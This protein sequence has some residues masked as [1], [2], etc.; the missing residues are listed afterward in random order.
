MKKA[1]KLTVCAI[2]LPALG[3]A[4]VRLP[5]LN[6][7][8][9]T[10][11]VD[12]VRDIQPIFQ[13]SCYPCH[14][15]KRAM[16]QLRFDE[17]SLAFKGGISG[18]VI[19]PGNSQ[20]S[21]LVQRLLGLGGEAQ[22]PM[23]GDPLPPEQIA[24]IRAWI[25]QGAG[26]PGA[27]DAKEE[28][29]P[30]EIAK[31]WA[32]VKPVRP[33]PP[34][35]KNAAWVRNPID[36]FVLARLEKEGLAPSPE[37]PKE[38]LIRRLYLDLIGLPPSPAEV[39]AFLAD[40]SND[41]YERLVDRLLASPH[42]GERWARPWLDLARYADTNGYEKDLRRTIWKYRDWVIN[43]FN[44]DMP[45]DQFTVEQIAGDMLPGATEEQKIASG[46][47]R[48]AMTNQE[49][50]VDQQE[51]LFEAILDRVSTTATVWLG[52]TLACAQCH[53]HKYDP[54]TQKEFYQFYAFFA[55]T[56]YRMEGDASVSEEKLIEPVLELP[57]AEQQARRREIETEIAGLKETLRTRTPELEAQQAVWEN[58]VRSS[59]NDWTPLDPTRLLS[60]G[61]ATLK[62]LSDT[63][64]L[65]SGANPEKDTYVIEARTNL[66]GITGLR[67]E[68]LP[69]ARLPRGGPGRDPYG[70]F[71]LTGFHAEIRAADGSAKAETLVFSDV[72]ADDAAK[73]AKNLIEQK[74][75]LSDYKPSGWAIDASKEETRLARQLVF[76]PEKP[77]GF[78]K[79][80][81]IRIVLKHESLDGGQGIGRFRLSVTTAKEP[82]KIV[83]ISAKLRPVLETPA[84]SRQEKQKRQLADFYL[85]IAPALKEARSRLEALQKSLKDLGIV[86]TLV[87][88]ERP[89][90][91]RPATPLRIRGSFTNPGDK[92]YAGVPAVLHPLPESQLPNR[93]G[94]A[95]W[96]VD[97]NNPLVARVT[98]NRFWE[99]LFGRGIVETSEDFGAQ[100]TPPTH[101]ELLDWLATEFMRQKWSMKAIIRLTVTSA[102]YR[103]SSKVTPELLERDPYNRLLARGSR[104]RMEAEMIRDVALAASGLL[105]RKIGGPSVFPYQPEGIW[106][107]PYN[108]D[109]WVMSK[110]EDRYRRGIYTFWRRTAPYPA[111]LPFDAPSR[112]T[113]TVRRVRTNTPLQ[114]LT[115]LND[116]AFFEMAK[117]LATRIL[118]EAPAT[119]QGRI[120]YGFR[121]CAARSPKPA[122]AERLA[123]LY[124]Q[125]IEQFTKDTDAAKKL[126]DGVALSGA[127]ASEAEF[128]AWSVVANV[129]LNLDETLTRE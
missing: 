57:T 55:N 42:Y 50:G 96:L 92:V 47:H 49:G 13:K 119:T 9:Q 23:G 16:G 19:I 80:T 31:H 26:W 7:S 36:N 113:C 2:F 34:A 99:Q 81:L 68:A 21:R 61:G 72:V 12:F 29:K 73:G 66:T 10:G 90:F 65:V 20:G 54:F 35:V 27:E 110:G 103:Q 59:Y 123:A 77:F 85:T 56:D 17:K 11:K 127:Q 30:A 124:Q 24:L 22:M 95:R 97:E 118:T 39:D 44:K 93:L 63:S 69:D 58:E 106:S 74:K 86:S 8:A 88:R 82:K 108:D 79:E 107:L 51:A 46:F 53:N 84:D 112:E 1:F 3:W 89:S 101:P 91:E 40:K 70:N 122:E 62:T 71:F 45:F 104:F 60:T 126:I 67:L 100:G 52:S 14:G 114:A 94:L 41:A 121:L 15:P 83:E 109:K 128:A 43:A 125:Q 32:Y 38:T 102:T 78:G 4:A 116:P 6:A 5:E 105:G 28:A 25:D 37:A 75:E 64:V 98:V 76:V 120:A 33:E 129:L 115:T 117:G 87:M 111:F 48:N 18:K